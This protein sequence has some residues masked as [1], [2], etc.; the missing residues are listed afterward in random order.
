MRTD[1]KQKE[2]KIKMIGNHKVKNQIVSTCFLLCLV[3]I[4]PL[5][6]SNAS[7]NYSS[8]EEK[9]VAD[10][11]LRYET[12]KAEM[13]L[14]HG[15]YA[16]WS[17]EA[18]AE[19]DQMLIDENYPIGDFVINTLPNPTDIQE[20]HAIELATSEIKEKLN[21][22]F[23]KKN[24]ETLLSFFSIPSE[25][26]R[27]WVVEFIN[28]SDQDEEKYIVEFTSPN[29]QVE[30]CAYYVN[31]IMKKSSFGSKAQAEGIRDEGS[32]NSYRTTV[33]K[34]AKQFMM[35]QYGF[36]EDALIYFNS[37]AK[38]SE[39]RGE[40]IVN[41]TSNKYNPS[42]V[43]TYTIVVN[44][45]TGLVIDYVWDLELDY[46]KQ[47]PKDPWKLADLWSSYEYNR[48]ANL[49]IESQNIIDQAG[50]ENKM[51]FEQHAAYDSLY[52]SAGYD[53][54]QYFRGLPSSSDA[55]PQEIKYLIQETV[56]EKYHI[57][58]EKFNRA[59]WKLAFDVSD[60][61][62]HYWRVILLLDEGTVYIR[63]E[64]DA[65]GTRVY[66]IEMI[67]GNNG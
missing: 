47:G 54:K 44:G 27:L 29:K 8:E 26:Q 5:L 35:D 51:S 14:T 25:N 52:R 39:E 56:K 40:W 45:E 7:A 42:K 28:S 58:S 60:S 23:D 49:K 55:S 59:E 61:S 41:F 46:Q 17:I 53:R 18:K 9:R 16:T 32:I 37:N 19:L 30:L 33:I 38:W 64:V 36:E 13:E 67:E 6:M 24:F 1:K 66:E 11:D 57:A 15:E 34:H 65:H 31:G 62:N 21:P 2:E 43:G 63:A 48:F 4:S 50:G 22:N 12:R 20:H 3:L 10:I